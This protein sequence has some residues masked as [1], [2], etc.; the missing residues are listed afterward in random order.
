MQPQIERAIYQGVIDSHQRFGINNND[1]LDKVAP[2]H[3]LLT[4]PTAID[5]E[6]LRPFFCY[7]STSRIKKSSANCFYHMQMPPVGYLHKRQRSPNP[8]AKIYCCCKTDCTDTTFS[9][10]QTIS[11]KGV[12]AE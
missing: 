3:R 8:A 2:L 5:H 1:I 6:A 10:T 12:E 9:D 11:V 7:L 4:K